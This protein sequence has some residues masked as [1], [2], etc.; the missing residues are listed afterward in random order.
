MTIGIFSAGELDIVIGFLAVF[1]VT[2]IDVAL[3]TI[4]C[5]NL[6]ENVSAGVHIQTDGGVGGA[7]GGVFQLYR[8]VVCLGGTGLAENTGISIGGECT[9]RGVEGTFIKVAFFRIGT[10]TNNIEALRDKLYSA[11]CGS[12]LILGYSIIAGVF[13]A[14][15][16]CII[17]H[18]QVAKGGGIVN[19]AA[20]QTIAIIGGLGRT[21]GNSGAGGGVSGIDVCADIT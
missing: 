19:S 9:A 3:L 18:G 13:R 20:G 15:D 4:R 7:V 21:A 11:G 1:G 5:Q 17:A 16:I 6:V 14:D 8:G 10:T 2:G 12:K